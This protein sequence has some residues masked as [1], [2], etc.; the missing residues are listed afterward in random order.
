MI[1][2]PEVNIPNNLDIDRALKEFELKS[3]T[4]QMQKAPEVSKNSDVPKIVQLTMK[5]TGVR[6]QKQV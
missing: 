2:P 4:E 6:E 5:W 3:Q 1:M